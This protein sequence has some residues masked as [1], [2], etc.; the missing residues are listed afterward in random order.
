MPER[1]NSEANS[2]AET[3][4]TRPPGSPSPRRLP[5]GAIVGGTRASGPVAVAALLALALAALGSDASEPEPPA[6]VVTLRADSASVNPGEETVLRAFGQVSETFRA[7]ADRIFTWNLDL[8][9]LAPEVMVLDPASLVR[10]RSDRDP[11]LGSVGTT[12]GPNLLG[13]RDSFLGFESAGVATAVELFSV[14]V[15]ALGNG[16]AHFR[17]RPGTL[18]A[19]ESPDFLVLPLGD[20]EPW[21]GGSYTAAVATF[22]VGDV[23]PTDPPALRIQRLAGGA[24][25]VVVEGPAGAS[26]ALEEADRIGDTL[27][28]RRVGESP[29]GTSTYVWEG[30]PSGAPRF[31][32]GVR[33]ATGRSE[34]RGPGSAM[35]RGHLPAGTVASGMDP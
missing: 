5:T 23:A 28:W 34:D 3:T 21:S 8:L 33:L 16:T 20:E 6:V 29:A 24:I 10:P 27:A 32:R 25:R 13:I 22:V 15:K 12:D 30:P 7:R 11:I 14:R 17:V 4:P 2:A 31:F 1:S 9:A 26:V 19:D 18:G 35:S